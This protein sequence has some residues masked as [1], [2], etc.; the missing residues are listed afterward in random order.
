MFSILFPISNCNSFRRDGILNDP[1]V[2]RLEAVLKFETEVLLI[3]S[4]PA[5]VLTLVLVLLPSRGDTLVVGMMVSENQLDRVARVSACSRAPP[6]QCLPDLVTV[7]VLGE[8]SRRSDGAAAG[9]STGTIGLLEGME[10]DDS[11]NL[12]NVSLM[13][14][15]HD[16]MKD[17][18]APNKR[19]LDDGMEGVRSALGVRRDSGIQRDP[20]WH[21]AFTCLYNRPGK[22]SI[23]LAVP[24]C[25]VYTTTVGFEAQERPPLQTLQAGLSVGDRANLP[26]DTHPARF[27]TPQSR[28]SGRSFR[29]PRRRYR[30]VCASGHR[31]TLK[32]NTLVPCLA[33]KRNAP[34]KYCTAR[35]NRARH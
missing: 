23:G 11:K 12:A 19:D 5:H 32:P 20:L 10:S 16:G 7:A 34:E 4:L 21:G 9:S 29:P 18:L 30:H 22:A 26:N 25:R 8:H 27:F 24:T 15:L 2:K 6:A 31:R 17:A 35:G 14:K 28:T 33:K 13:T 3:L 1:A